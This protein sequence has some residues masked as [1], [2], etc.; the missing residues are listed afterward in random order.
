MKIAVTGAAGFIGSHLCD[1]LLA[2]G[3]DVIG[4]DNLCIGSMNHVADALKHKRFVFK[5]VDVCDAKALAAACRGVETIVH[6]AAYKIPIGEMRVEETLLVNTHGTENVL[7][8]ARKD[9]AKVVF[10]STSDVYGKSRDFPFREDGDLVLG[11]PKVSRWSYAASKI[12]DEHLC[13]AYQN[14]FGLPIVIL[15]YFNSYGPRHDLTYVSGGPQ[16]L[17]IQAILKGEPITVYGDGMQKRCFCYISDTVDGTVR[18]IENQKAIGEVFNI[19]NDST[20]ISILDLA[21]FIHRLCATGKKL[22]INFKPHATLGKYEEVQKR[23]PDVSKA[24][25]ILGF[26]PRV[27][28]EEGL[29][30]TIEW[31]KSLLKK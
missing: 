16:A 17:F 11:A 6:E 30:K 28:N 9:D 29:K 23:V 1:A 25:R 2:K 8:I 20:E 5:K 18:A 7:E 12:F 15:R 21:K 19:G 13:F 4:V 3:H 22:E 31:H 10:A 24:K 27:G 26:A 14:S